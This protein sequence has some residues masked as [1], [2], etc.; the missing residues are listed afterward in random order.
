MTSSHT[1]RV[2]E[3]VRV[4]SHRFHSDKLPQLCQGMALDALKVGAIGV[5]QEHILLPRSPWPPTFVRLLPPRS[6]SMMGICQMQM[7]L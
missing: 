2:K 1:K 6:W 3:T 7:G 5:L 4:I